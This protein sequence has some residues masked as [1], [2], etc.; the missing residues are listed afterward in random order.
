MGTLTKCRF[1]LQL[2]KSE[3]S[4]TVFEYLSWKNLFQRLDKIIKILL[5]RVYCCVDCDVT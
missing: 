5:M 3:K 2:G 4:N 1:N